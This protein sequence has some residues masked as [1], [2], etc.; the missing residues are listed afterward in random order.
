MRA[1]VCQSRAPPERPQAESLDDVSLSSVWKKLRDLPQLICLTEAGAAVAA[2]SIFTSCSGTFAFSRAARSNSLWP[3][4]TNHVF[5][6]VHDEKR[7]IVGR[8][9]RDR[10]G[11]RD[12]LFV[13]LNRPADSFRF[14]RL[15]VV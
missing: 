7:R 3:Y 14:R 11:P 1:V 6:A 5:V 2:P 9:I 15:L 10:I 13:L 12:F 4:G 8:N